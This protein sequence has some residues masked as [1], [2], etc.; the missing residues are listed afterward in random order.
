MKSQV[1]HAHTSTEG[2]TFE[3][4]TMSSCLVDVDIRTSSNESTT[5]GNAK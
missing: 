1:S 4:A 2:R 5:M 3:E